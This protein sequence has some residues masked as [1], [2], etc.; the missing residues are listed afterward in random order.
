MKLPEKL[1]KR[2]CLGKTAEMFDLCGLITPIM[3]G[4]KLDIRDLVLLGCNWDDEIPDVNRKTWIENLKLM[5]C[6]SDI[7]YSRVI[8]PGDAQSLSME[9]IGAGDA[10]AKMTCAGCYARFKLKN[11]EY[12]CLRLYQMV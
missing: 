8:V 2:I 1:T 4:L 5:E 9:L 6:A 3:A 10:S 7:K 11:N 12:S